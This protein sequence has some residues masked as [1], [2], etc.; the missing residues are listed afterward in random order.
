MLSPE[1]S[2]LLPSPQSPESDDVE[3]LTLEDSGWHSTILTTAWTKSAWLSESTAWKALTLSL[4][5]SLAVSAVNLTFLSAWATSSPRYDQPASTT[6]LRPLDYPSVYVGLERVAHDPT[7]CL[8]RETFPD[9]F[10]TYDARKGPGATLKRVH[11]LEDEVT[12]M[13][14][15]PIRAVV[16]T[17]VLDYGLENCTFIVHSSNTTH[18]GQGRSMDVYLL[19]PT[20]KPGE[21]QNG[22]L[23]D[24]LSFI[25]GKDNIS[26]PFHCPS[27]SRIGFEL[28]CAE[29]DC[30]VHVP[31]QGVTSKTASSSSIVKTGFRMNQYEAVNCISGSGGK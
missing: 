27:R 21:G 31:L 1:Y 14:G 26:R 23:L 7:R 6:V 25:P 13:F 16:E 22:M 19:G 20:G 24:R 4:I 28:R 18:L 11:A 5:L 30:T 12:L 17:R 15:G 9:T 29:G 10:Y 3:L 8:S 2:R